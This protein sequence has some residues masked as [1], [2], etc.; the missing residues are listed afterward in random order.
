[1]RA[2]EC[3]VKRAARCRKKSQKMGSQIRTDMHKT[4]PFFSAAM[5]EKIQAWR[6]FL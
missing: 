3:A 5:P 1:M 4:T 2:L 6:F